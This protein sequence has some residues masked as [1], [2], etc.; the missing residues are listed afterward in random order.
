MFVVEALEALRNKKN[1]DGWLLRMAGKVKE[2]QKVIMDDADWKETI[3]GENVCT[4]PE[5]STSSFP[6]CRSGTDLL[7]QQLSRC[8]K[9]GLDPVSA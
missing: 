4:F 6:S 9:A 1:F 8:I 7:H 2:F 5:Y 3:N